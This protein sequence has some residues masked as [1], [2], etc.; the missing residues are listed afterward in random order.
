MQSV[1]GMRS[2]RKRALI[3]AAGAA[4]AISVALLWSIRSRFREDRLV[5][6][7]GALLASAHE[8]PY[9]TVAARLSLPFDYRP[10]TIRRSSRHEWHMPD[11][12]AEIKQSADIA[13]TP[14]NLH[15]LGL[16]YL[17]GGNYAE[18]VQVLQQARA[19]ASDPTIVNG[20]AAAQYE[21]GVKDGMAVDIAQ[22]L[23]LSDMILAR[24]SGDRSALFNRALALERLQNRPSALKAWQQ[25]LKFD[26]SSEWTAEVQQH[27]RRSLYRLLRL[28]GSHSNRNSCNPIRPAP[29]VI[30]GGH[31]ALGGDWPLDDALRKLLG[32]GTSVAQEALRPICSRGLADDEVLLGAV[33]TPMTG[34]GM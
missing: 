18:A 22:S 10:M 34:K 4:I 11:I 2:P 19:M 20:L 3:I 8:L 29:Y 1:A 6:A 25:Y 5:D 14:K 27:V 17:F 24:S 32:N 28:N 16:S 21:A 33:L 23:E 15:L 13:P 31:K 26:V 30:V 7:T 12:V 9:R